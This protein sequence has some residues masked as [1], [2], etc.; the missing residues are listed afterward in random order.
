M[1]FIGLMILT[2][3]VL[4]CSRNTSSKVQ[5]EKATLPDV[6][7]ASNTTE[8]SDISNTS[9]NSS[10][11]TATSV[12]NWEVE[13]P[14]GTT[15]SRLFWSSDGKTVVSD[16]NRVQAWDVKTKALIRDYNAS[17]FTSEN[18]KYFALMFVQPDET[19]KIEI[20][21]FNS[22][23]QPNSLSITLP[24][25]K[26]NIYRNL[27]LSN[28]GKKFAIEFNDHTIPSQMWDV[29]TMTQDFEYYGFET[30]FSANGRII[31]VS[32]PTVKSANSPSTTDQ[33]DFWDLVSHKKLSESYRS[34]TLY[35]EFSPVG[36]DLL[37][38]TERDVYYLSFQD[39]PDYAAESL[40]QQCNVRVRG[41]AHFSPNGG[42][43][44]LLCM[45]S[46]RSD[47]DGNDLSSYK[48]ILWNVKTSKTLLSE[49]TVVGGTYFAPNGQ[50]LA[51]GDIMYDLI[52]H[53]AFG[54]NRN[55]SF[56]HDS[57]YIISPNGVT[58]IANPES[59]IDIFASLTG[60]V[61]NF[62]LSP[63]GKSVFVNTYAFSAGTIR[64][65]IVNF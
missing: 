3:S 50:Y 54:I 16:G 47:H 8:N 9:S 65:A 24:N 37:V 40:Q 4:A 64:L 17:L 58:E 33:I 19:I 62:A 39:H 45:D 42:L 49:S 51:V 2:I 53:S 21:D 7:S 57:R 20:T 25:K 30:K 48:F 36:Q 56:S 29:A 1:K 34:K 18:E 13:L 31:A 63:D 55:F 11:S 35:F 14:K 5:T 23:S 61:K 32:A 41:Y 60:S 43:A 38:T 59:T 12:S 46:Y 22:A 44:A 15:V 10:S 28:D 26:V 52:S 6:A 27:I